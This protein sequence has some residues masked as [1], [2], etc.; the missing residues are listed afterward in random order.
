[1]NCPKYTE[2]G[3]RCTLPTG[4]PN[5]CSADP[6]PILVMTQAG[7]EAQRLVDSYQREKPNLQRNPNCEEC[8]GRSYNELPEPDSFGRVV[9]HSICRKCGGYRY[10]SETR[11]VVWASKPERNQRDPDG[12]PRVPKTRNGTT[13]TPDLT[14]ARIAESQRRAG[15][16]RAP[17]AQS[18]NYMAEAAAQ[19]EKDYQAMT[20][21][22]G[23]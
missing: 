15:T 5:F 8:H 19:A 18:R 14:A 4:H 13:E 3:K 6:R 22:N 10:T 17:K 7:V 9:E 1:M 11:R 2:S 12:Q 16:K 21:W 23:F 20:Q